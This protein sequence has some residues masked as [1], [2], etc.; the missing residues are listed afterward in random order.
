MKLTVPTDSLE[1]KKL[2]PGIYEA[3]FTGMK[4]EYSKDKSSINFKPQLKVIG[5]QN[6][7]LNGQPVFITIS[8]K[9]G[10]IQQDFAHGLGLDM[11]IDGKNASFP[12]EI[13]D[14]G[15][16]DNPEKWTYK[17]PFDGRTLKCEVVES[18]YQGKTSSKVKQIFCAVAGCSS[19]VPPVKHSTDLTK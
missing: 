17:G 10:W 2:P 1:Q 5:N 3:V 15:S 13:L 18:T 11:E 6:T 14:N 16:P 9:A 4:F 19:R 12:G 7:D 8:Q